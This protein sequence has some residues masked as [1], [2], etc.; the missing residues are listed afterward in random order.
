MISRR[1]LLMGGAAVAAAASAPWS[2]QAWLAQTTARL[3]SGTPAAE[4]IAELSDSI[5]RLM[6]EHRVPGLSI[7][8]I[9]DA[10]LLWTQGF[11]I[12]SVSTKEPVTP[13]TVF[14]AASLSKPAFAYAALRL[15]ERDKRSLDV[16]LA[17]YVPATFVT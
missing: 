17:E 11:G 16:P 13:D 14:E 2:L 9:R 8:V 5:P 1:R 4:L 10:S 3:T 6:D 7:A 15:F 12:K